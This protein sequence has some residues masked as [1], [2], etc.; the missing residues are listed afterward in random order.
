MQTHDLIEALSGDLRRVEP[1]ALERRLGA[2]V[3]I[4]MIITLVLVVLGLG[5]RPDLAQAVAGSMFW[6][7][8]GYTASIGL[9]ALTV[10]AALARPDAGGIGALR[11]LLVPIAL[12]A[13]VGL[14]N[15]SQTPV[16]GWGFLWLGR[17]WKSCPFLIFGLSIPIYLGLIVAFR[18][19]APSR[20]TLTGGVAGL[21]AGGL[22][23]TLY[24]VHCPEA[25]ALFVLT[26]Y[27]LGM[28]LAGLAGALFGRR[29][30]R[31]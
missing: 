9:G 3:I 12:M 27:T 1:H 21:A 16:S 14:I 10:T 23:A 18:R 15:L 2:A 26:W 4:G 22:A 25:S 30:L 31:W 29:L 24:C 6:L 28:A 5:L 7:K 13:L 11:W 19:F 20:L 8:L 17:S